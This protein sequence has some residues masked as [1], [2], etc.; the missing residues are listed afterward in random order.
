MLISHRHRF[1]VFLDPLGSCQWVRR[2]LDPWL[3][4][5]VGSSKTADTTTVFF[6]G[7]SPAEAE[8]AF[9]M[10]GHPFRNYM[11]IAIVQNP[12]VRIVQLYDRIAAVD[13]IWQARR[14]LGLQN[15]D[16]V[17]WLHHTRADGYGAGY[18][19]GPRWRRFGSWSA[20]TWCD[21]RISHIARAEH[22]KE[23]LQTIFRQRDIALSI[24]CRAIGQ[25]SNTAI[26]MERYDLASATLIQ[27]RYASDLGFY[28]Q[29]QNELSLVA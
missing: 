24:D 26:E 7:M 21:G 29:H 1:V 16:F 13:P 22:A 20:D 19:R 25:N 3:D 18:P 11:R 28:Q 17:R 8:L 14:R 23:D 27:S 4:Q 5:P 12:F 6:H 2:T 10:S 15:P 9:D